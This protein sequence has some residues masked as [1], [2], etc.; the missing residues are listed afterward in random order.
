MKKQSQFNLSKILLLVGILS[1]AVCATAFFSY[2]LG[3]SNRIEIESSTTTL[4][5][6]KESEIIVFEQDSEPEKDTENET[7]EIVLVPIDETLFEYVEVVDGCGIHYE[8]ECVLVR[9]G[10]GLEFDVVARLR[11]DQVLKVD[12]SVTRKGMT[13][14]KV[15]FD[16][17]LLYPERLQNDWYVSADYV[18]VLYDEGDKTIWDT[19]T[20]TSTKQIIVDLSEQTLTATEDGETFMCVDI[21]SGLAMTP[22]PLGTFTIFKKTPSRYMQGPLPGLSSDQTYDLPGVPWNLYF[23][24]DGAVIHG[25][26]WHDSF[27]STYSHGCVNLLP[28][29]AKKLYLWA[30]LGMDVVVQN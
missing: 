8:G 16:E 23:T 2:N 7:K 29:E 22:T 21:S 1:V 14:Y 15:V 6:L 13:W 20:G 19:E 3:T 28:E 4:P 17:W 9:S 12:G 5:Y 10:P 24:H 11:N 25:A 30:D 18:S 26:Y 27:G